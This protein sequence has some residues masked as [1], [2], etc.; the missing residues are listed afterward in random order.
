MDS[1]Q[2]EVHHVVVYLTLLG[3]DKG[4]KSLRRFQI[5]GWFMLANKCLIALLRKLS[6]MWLF[7][8]ENKS[9]LAE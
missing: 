4:P 2:R 9:I 7:I 6:A 5:R 1:W 3:L 8:V